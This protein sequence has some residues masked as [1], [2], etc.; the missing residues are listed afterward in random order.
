MKAVLTFRRVTIPLTAVLLIVLLTLRAS[1]AVTLI[2]FTIDAEDDRVRL[3]WKTGTELENAGF[4][5]LRNAGSDE[6]GDS[7][8]VY[9][10]EDNTTTDFIPAKGDSVSGA[11]YLVYDEN[12]DPGTTYF[13]K[14]EDVANNNNTTVHDPNP[15]SVTIPSDATPTSTPTNTSTATATPTNTPTRTPM[16]TATATNTPQPTHT[17]TPVPST[18]P[19]PTATPRPASP[20][21]TPIPSEAGRTGRA[22]TPTWTP[23]ATATEG[24][25][26]AADAQNVTPS[27][28]TPPTLTPDVDSATAYPPPVQTVPATA[29]ALPQSPT[30][31]PPL[32]L[33]NAERANVEVPTTIVKPPA[34]FDLLAFF[35]RVLTILIGTLTIAFIGASVWFIRIS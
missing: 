21:A 14:L 6:E 17:N 18:T 29:E 19:S 5:V 1:A 33:A 11:D 7:I 28:T 32:A 20:T 12:V 22:A 34:G 16:P 27:P 35:G 31:T 8:E 13:Y 23:R 9:V 3:E 15:L 10:P 30:P 24:D 25:G 4:R 26:G 2:S